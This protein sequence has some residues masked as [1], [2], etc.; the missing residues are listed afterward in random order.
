MVIHNPHKG[1]QMHRDAGRIT[2]LWELI[3]AAK[4]DDRYLVYEDERKAAKDE[5]PSPSSEDFCEHDEDRGCTD[6]CTY[7]NDFGPPGGITRVDG[8]F[9]APFR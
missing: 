8:H 5:M 9:K 4:E 6:Q 3:Q 7:G 2:N 1:L